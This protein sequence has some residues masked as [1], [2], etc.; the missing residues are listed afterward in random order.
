MPNKIAAPPALDDRRFDD[1][2][3]ELLA[4]VPAHTPDWVP[5][6]GD[7]GRTL[8]E[9]FAWLADT[10]LYR[11]NLVPEKQRLAF[12]NLLGKPLEPAVPAS[13]LVSLAVNDPLFTESLGIAKASLI[14]GPV[15]FETV[16]DIK[17]LPVVGEFYYKRGISTTEQNELRDVLDELRDFHEIE[18]MDAYITE[19]AFSPE[20]QANT[21]DLARDTLDN[22]LWLALLAP[23]PALVEDVRSVLAGEAEGT[24]QHLQLGFAPGLDIP[25]FVDEVEVGGNIPFSV[26]ISTGEISDDELLYLT[27]DH[28]DTTNKLTQRGTIQ[29]V[30][31][32]D[33]RFIGVAEGDVRR[34]AN[35]GLGNRPPRIDDPEKLARIVTWLKIEIDPEI[36]SAKIKWAAINAVRIDQRQ[37]VRAQ[38]IGQSNGSADQVFKLPWAAIDKNSLKVEVE[39]AGR[40]YV[41]WVAVDDLAI[42]NRDDNGFV[43]DSGSSTLNFGNGVY[44]RIPETGSRIRIAYA[45]AGGGKAGNLPVASLSDINARAFDGSVISQALLVQ[46][47][48]ATTG[49]LDAETLAEAEKRIPAWLKNRNRAVVEDDYKQLAMQAPGVELG[50]VEVLPKFLPQQR[51]DGVPGVVSVMVLP[52]KAVT[53]YPNPR[54]D[55]P[56]IEKVFNYLDARKA[57]T[58]ELYV[59]GC[60]YRRIALSIAISVRSGFSHDA[61]SFAVKDALKKYLWSLAPHGPFGDGWPL[62]RTVGDRELEVVAAR[63]EGVNGVGGCN[64]F[65]P[66]SNRWK[67]I[68]RA[69]ACDPANLA[70]EN[71]QLPELMGV[72]V[73]VGD[74]PADDLKGLFG[75]TSGIGAGVAVPVIPE[76]C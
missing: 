15:K 30:L 41:P 64:L 76:V 62:G 34:D 7:P 8:I 61:V 50:R 11:A 20:E 59:I 39:E 56:L 22:T 25:E 6:E 14:N 4:R 52:K 19:L 23:A 24:A 32:G 60:E 3:E 66:E 71:W 70:L 72:V 31:P 55:K 21:L 40:G 17:I 16:E 67:K 35:A 68:S 69:K 29:V 58:T 51:R 9:L 43:L 36:Q 73:S 42:I 13:G 75:S 74:S 12:L 26:S 54:I 27:L 48:I 45:R 57:L 53:E 37:T 28:S 47:N 44:G 5:Q 46:Q 63:V 38:V 10:I 65:V 49:G 2:V 18:S 1:L 33:R